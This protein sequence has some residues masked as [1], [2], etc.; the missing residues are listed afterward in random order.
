MSICMLCEKE[1]PELTKMVVRSDNGEVMQ[2]KVMGKKYESGYICPDCILALF[3]SSCF[4]PIVMRSS[5][6]KGVSP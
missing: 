1:S 2:A 5:E 4:S 3:A 6:N